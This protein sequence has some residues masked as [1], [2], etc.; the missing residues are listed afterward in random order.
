M[1]LDSTL[2]GPQCLPCTSLALPSRLRVCWTPL[3]WAASLPHWS[4]C[5]PEVATVTH[6]QLFFLF[7][8]HLQQV[9]LLMRKVLRDCSDCLSER[10][11][12]HKGTAAISVFVFVSVGN[13]CTTTIRRKEGKQL[14]T[15]WEAVGTILTD[16][17]WMMWDSFTI[18]ADIEMLTELHTPSF[19]VSKQ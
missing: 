10:S 19:L 1:K 4:F 5:A 12:G 3:C 11:V 16:F 18:L 13:E 2:W 8:S 7:L 9:G 15:V 6:P 14:L 17:L